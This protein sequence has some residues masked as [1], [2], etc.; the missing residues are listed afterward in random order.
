MSKTNILI[1]IVCVCIGGLL[2]LW[3]GQDICFDLRNY[4]LYIPYAFL[5]GRESIDLLA[6][7]PVHTFFNPLPDIPYYLIFSYLNNWPKITGFLM[8]SYYGLSLFILYKWVTKIITGNS[9]STYFLQT[10]TCIFA[11]TGMAGFLQI[12]MFSNEELLTVF[13][14]LA[15]Y[16]L[17]CGTDER[18]GFQLKYLAGAAFLVS[19]AAGLKYTAAPAA[20]G[21][22]LCC[23]FLLIKNKASYKAYLCVIGTAVAGF[24][25]ADGYFLWHKW[26]ELGNPLFPYF[27]HIFKSPLF[28]HTALANSPFVPHGWK[29]RLFLPFLRLSFFDSEYR[30]DFRILWGYI[31]FILLGAGG[32]FYIKKRPLFKPYV[33]LLGL[34]IGTYIPWVIFFGNIRYAIFL[35]ILSSLLLVCLSVRFIPVKYLSGLLIGLSAYSVNQS[36]SLWPRAKFVSQNITFSQPVFIED[37]SLVVMGGHFS[38]LIPFL[39]PN[40][41]Y[42]GGIN[43]QSGKMPLTRAKRRFIAP[44]QRLDYRHYFPVREEIRNH[45][46]QLY[47]LAPYT[48]WIWNN[49]FW[50]DYGIDVSDKHCQVFRTNFLRYPFF[51]CVVKKTAQ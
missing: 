45:Q 37:N 20:I 2:S 43:F 51:L 42:I 18:F 46:G 12:G 38:F 30:L 24:L 5:H 9:V 19:F 48:K 7:G 31:S 47:L 26:K 10:A 3:L 29:E 32:L 33:L 40:A 49:D 41:R 44:L 6:A 28:P 11:L 17:F 36:L 35:E 50:N 14:V 23:L 13:A 25:L 27:N 34:F 15:A 4:H 16:L 39:N 21:V 22:G 8:G 1:F